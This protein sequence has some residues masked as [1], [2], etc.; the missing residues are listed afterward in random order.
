MPT[1]RSYERV[2][3]SQPNLPRESANWMYSL[4]AAL[5][6]LRAQSAQNT[7]NLEG[8][9][10]LALEILDRVSNMG[11]RAEGEPLLVSVARAAQWLNV[12]EKTIMRRIKN[13][14]LEGMQDGGV[15]RVT[16]ASIKRYIER[17]RIESE[18]D[19]DVN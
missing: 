3:P 5:G 6:E 14:E 13:G 9:N 16:T 12:S 17:N 7:T 10:L 4:H 1:K 2:L 8:L 18:D 19:H 15:L 11:L